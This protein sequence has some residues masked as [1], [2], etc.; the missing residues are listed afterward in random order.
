[1]NII[2]KRTTMKNNIIINMLKSAGCLGAAALLLA[3]CKAEPDDSTLYT[4]TGFTVEQYLA[5]HEDLSNF[6][7]IVKQARYDRILDSYG[8]YTVFAP[9]NAAV[10]NYIDS[11]YRDPEKAEENPHNGM[12]EHG[13]LA[14]GQHAQL[15]WLTDSLCKDITLYHIA[16]SSQTGATPITI[17]DMSSDDNNKNVTTLLGRAITIAIDP[18]KGPLLNEQ[19]TITNIDEDSEDKT[20]VNGIVHTIS[21]VLPRSNR[22]VGTQM[23]K[24]DGYALFS[25]A[26]EKTGLADSLLKT[27]KDKAVY[28]KADEDAGHLMIDEEYESL[29]KYT[30]FAESDDVFRAAG[31]NTFADLV[32]YANKV[33]ADA[34]Q[35][36]DYLRQYGLWSETAHDYVKTVST[37]NDYTSRNN[38][39]NM[40]VAYHLL[41]YGLRGD[42]VTTY[43]NV[44]PS[45]R[46]GWSGDSYDYYCTMLPNTLV[47]AWTVR[48]LSK[49]FLN[50]CVANNTM[51]DDFESL[52]KNQ[53]ALHPVLIDGVELN[54]AFTETLNGYIYNI[55][56]P[57]V[58]NADVKNKVLNER[59]R[60]D[61][62][63]Q[64]PEIMSN[65]WRYMYTND[66]GKARIR[67]AND[68][69][70]GIRVYNGNNTHLGMN[71][72]ASLNTSSDKSYSLYQGDSF[73]GTG[74]ADFAIKLPP[75]PEG[76]YELRLDFT[77]AGHFGIVQ[78]YLGRTNDPTDMQTLDIPMDCRMSA[79][80]PRVGWTDPRNDETYEIDKGYTA[81][82]DL[83]NRKWM[84]GLLSLVRENQK[85]SDDWIV[86][87]RTD[88]I[89]RIVYT[90]HF[91]QGDYWLRV[92]SVL[93]DNPIAVFQLDYVEFMPLDLVTHPT[94][95]EDMY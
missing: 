41:G 6:N 87:Y 28:E 32:T 44:V 36:Y 77:F 89:R 46:H 73:R 61:W 76:D 57:L 34:D 83:R 48:K 2:I 63:S 91:D 71:V 43:F 30:V 20:A 40:F 16:G 93:T 80:D 9:N 37:G 29:V 60:I 1:M 8:G 19:V 15:E 95:M 13:T 81:D 12:A 75:V 22:L 66:V 70:D 56:S 47:K 84:R 35:W 52:G 24:M 88:Q 72:R 58:Y 92:K 67:F 25:E 21:D 49:T 7:Y 74:R 45:G 53:E 86:R 54:R 3:S 55:G 69:F 18:A 85:T 38:A 90:G 51:T 50:R 27:K 26:L 23:A 65:G 14:E 79:D 64:L 31:I 39:L 33:Y 17:M 82:K 59:L 4:F 42:V 10:Q 68:F 11:L 62:L 94:L 5:Q 78:Y